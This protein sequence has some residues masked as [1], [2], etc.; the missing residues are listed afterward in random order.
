MKQIPVQT[1]QPAFTNR[2]DLDGSV[3]LIRFEWQTRSGWY[4][5]ISAAS[6]EVLMS[7]RRMV[8]DWDLLQQQTDARLP[9]G[10]LFLVDDT[11]EHEEAGYLDLGVRH[12]VVYLTAAEMTALGA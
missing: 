12:S 5:G 9:A 8:V 10:G 2:V 1:E 11:G 7:L 3:Y 4:V 6:G